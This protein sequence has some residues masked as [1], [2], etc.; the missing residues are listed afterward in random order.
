MPPKLD[1]PLVFV[2]VDTQRDFLEPSGALFIEGSPAILAN[3]ARLTHFARDRGIPVIA[4]ACA[5]TSDS[6][7]FATFAPHCLIGTTGHERVKDKNI[8]AAF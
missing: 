1:G 8:E 6:A 3:L 5:H 4:T 7:E 2:D